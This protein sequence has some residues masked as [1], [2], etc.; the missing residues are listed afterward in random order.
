MS[1]EATGVARAGALMLAD[2][3]GWFERVARGVYALTPQGAAGLEAF[4][5]AVGALDAPPDQ[6]V[7]TGT[8][9]R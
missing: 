8:S 7:G 5:E 2:H 3:Y 9:P 4:A 6:R 1:P